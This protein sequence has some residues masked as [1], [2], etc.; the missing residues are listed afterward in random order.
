MITEINLRKV[1]SYKNQA[2]LETDKKINI[3][4]GLNGT[5]KSILSDYLLKRN[6]EKFKCCSIEGLNE[7]HEVYVYNQTF[8][9]DNFFESES[10][11]GIFTISKENKLAEKNISISRKEIEKLDEEKRKKEIEIDKEKDHFRKKHKMNLKR[12]WKIKTDFSS[13]SN[14]ILD[15]CLEGYKSSKANLFNYII[16]LPK[17]TKKPSESIEDLKNKAQTIMGANAKKYLLVSDVE[18][19]SASIETKK[20]FKKKIVGA[21]NSSLSALIKQLGNSDWVKFGLKYLPKDPIR[22]NKECPFCQERTVSNEFLQNIKDYFDD[23]YQS[24]INSLK[25]YSK[26]YSQ[27][28]QKINKIKYTLEANSIFETIPELK[29][30]KIDFILKFDK[31]LR[32]INNNRVKIE[33]KIKTPSLSKTLESSVK[34]LQE[35]NNDIGRINEL[36]SDHNKDI[37]QKEIRK[38]KIKQLFWEIMRWDYNE[39]IEKYLSDKTKSDFKLKALNSCIEEYKTKISSHNLIISE[40]Q[41]LTKNIEEAVTNINMGLIDLGIADFKIENF[42]NNFYKIVREENEENEVFRS[43]SEGEK[44]IISFLY[45]LEMCKGSETYKK[46]IIVIDD[47]ISSLSHIYVFNIG[48]LIKNE[49]I[50]SKNSDYVQVFILT[51]SLYFFNEII[52]RNYTKRKK[53]YKLFRLIKNSEGSH[54]QSMEHGE[55]QNDYHEYWNIIKDKKNPNALIAN[56][57]RSVIEYFF[58]FVEKEDLTSFFKREPLSSNKF[59]AFN[60]YINRESHSLGQNLFDSNDFDYEVFKD[61]LQKLFEV[62]GYKNHYEKM[63]K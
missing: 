43:L 3:V 37:E 13:G 52:E 4:Y 27:S 51:H 41:K 61:G 56:C 49:F 33:Q 53:S 25:T 24:D 19:L 32:L 1:A 2:T 42:S 30:H 5:G 48:V 6:D 45:F 38:E 63:I 35:I 8:I 15:F 39:E 12:I 20:I 29:K 50:D 55:I 23:S 47:P 36:I 26:E 21:E 7:N 10:L 58:N 40:Q 22:E 11:K 60:R 46:K 18:F 62:A 28:V 31:F 59:Q 9:Q 57:I 17:L 44:M 16:S 54:F 14:Y 34:L